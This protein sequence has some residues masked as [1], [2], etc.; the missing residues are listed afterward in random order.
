VSSFFAPA[1][2]AVRENLAR[3]RASYTLTIK[4]SAS[5]GSGLHNCITYGAVQSD[6]D[7]GTRAFDLTRLGLCAFAPW[8]M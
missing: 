1:L 8:R 5:S 7:L 2:A 6:Q 4:A 3:S